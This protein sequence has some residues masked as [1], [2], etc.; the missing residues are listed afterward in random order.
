[1]LSFNVNDRILD[2]LNDAYACH[3][4][5]S[6]FPFEPDNNAA[7]IDTKQVNIPYLDRLFCATNPDE[8]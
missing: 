3:C 2:Q 4:E 8:R 1:M 5:A 6:K 7:D